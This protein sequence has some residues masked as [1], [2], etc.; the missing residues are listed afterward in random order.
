MSVFAA[1]IYVYYACLVLGEVRRGHQVP[2]NWSYSK[3]QACV[4]SGKHT[5]I[6]C[7]SRKYCWLLSPLVSLQLPEPYKPSPSTRECFW[8]IIDRANE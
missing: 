6:F 8:A 1:C 4:C 5:W 2:K 3:P 7:K